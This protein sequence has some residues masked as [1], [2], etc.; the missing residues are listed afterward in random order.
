MRYFSSLSPLCRIAGWNQKARPFLYSAFHIGDQVI[1]IN[2]LPV[3]TAA[4]AQK[5]IKHASS[6]E[7]VAFVVRRVPYA[8]MFAIKRSAEGESLGF[9]RDGGTAEVSRD[10]N[11]KNFHDTILLLTFPKSFFNMCSSSFYCYNQ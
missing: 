5:I 1:S 2:G 6:E 11:L 10:W 4:E 7:K 9:R 8:K 3:E